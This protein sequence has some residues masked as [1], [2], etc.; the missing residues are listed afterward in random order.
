MHIMVDLET[1]GLAAGNVVVS[2][3]LCSFDENGDI[4]GEMDLRIDIAD[5]QKCGLTIDAS[6]VKWW[7]KQS[8]SAQ[9]ATFVD[10]EFALTLKGALY[11]TIDFFSATPGGIDGVWANSPSMDLVLLGH[12]FK[13][14]GI[15]KPWIYK[16]ERDCR[17][18]FELTQIERTLPV[19][20]HSA[21]EDAK[22]QARD[23][24]RAL[25]V[26]KGKIDAARI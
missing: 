24:A 7:M 9:R 6:T 16:Q 1:L 13:L 20:A 18:I 17:T 2:I 10:D 21:L 19:I 22:A 12:C 25:R 5:A 14:C 4:Y 26:L 15:P 11:K 23:T 8:H 3:G